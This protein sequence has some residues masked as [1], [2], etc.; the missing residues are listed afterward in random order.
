VIIG[1]DELESGTILIRSMSTG[2]QWSVER[3]DVVSNIRSF[4]SQQGS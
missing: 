4:L 3:A 2:D 1:T